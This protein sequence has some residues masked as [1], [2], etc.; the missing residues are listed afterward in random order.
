MRLTPLR[1]RARPRGQSAPPR[2]RRCSSRLEPDSARP[3]GRPAGL[4]AT[5]GLAS[6]QSASSCAMR[7]GMPDSRAAHGP[8]DVLHERLS[9][10]VFD[11][12]KRWMMVPDATG[13]SSMVCTL[14]PVRLAVSMM[15]RLACSRRAPVEDL[16]DDRVLAVAAMVGRAEPPPS[17][18]RTLDRDGSDPGL[19]RHPLAG[20]GQELPG[21]L[22]WHAGRHRDVEDGLLLGHAD[23]PASL[24]LLPAALKVVHPAPHVADPSWSRRARVM[25]SAA[26]RCRKRRR[27]LY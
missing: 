3:A 2:P 25:P 22:R 18:R 13:S 23:T 26:D 5:V 21:R 7:L 10:F 8:V 12:A 17:P 9:R 1:S 24:L 16:L 19:P 6:G 4:R 11:A 27:T 14:Y 15:V 20:L